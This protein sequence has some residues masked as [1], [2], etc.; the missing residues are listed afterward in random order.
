[1]VSEPDIAVADLA[2]LQR[3]NLRIY[4]QGGAAELLGIKATTLSSRIKTMGLKKPNK[5]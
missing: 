2:A 3:T 4:G 5:E 1:M